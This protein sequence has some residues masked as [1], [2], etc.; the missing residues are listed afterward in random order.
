MRPARR[1]LSARYCCVLLVAC[2]SGGCGVQAMAEPSLVLFDGRVFTA[3]PARPEAQ[4]IAI[5]GE[6]IVAVGDDATILALAGST[7]RRI[8][9]GGRRVIPGLNDAH[10]H[11]SIEPADEVVADPGSP[12]PDWTGLSAALRRAE[13]GAARGAWLMATFGTTLFADRAV[14]RTALDRLWP[15]HPV[16][17]GSFDG[18]AAILN[19]A[20]LRRLGIGEDIADPAGG[21]FER[22][23]GGRLNG[24]VRE[25]ALGQVAGRLADLTSDADALAGLRHQIEAGARWGLTTIQDMPACG[26]VARQ[27]RLLAQMPS[28]IRIRLTRMNCTTPTGPDFDQNRDVGPHP[29]RLVSVNGTKWL[30]DGVTFE[31]TLTPRGTGLAQTAAA[32]GP[33]SPHDLAALPALFPPA[34]V[35][36]MLRDGLRRDEQL[37]FHVYGTPAAAELLDAMARTGGAAVWRGRRLRMEH[38]DGLTPALLRRA[39]AMGVVL[40][41]QGTHLDIGAI[42][43]GLLPGLL[44]RMRAARAEP[45]RS[46]LTAGMPLAL[47]SDGPLNPWLSIAGAV[48]DANRPDEAIS[49]TQA[50]LAYTAGSAFAEFTEGDRGRLIAGRLADLTVLDRD[51]LVVPVSALPDTHALLTV[52][53]GA[54]VWDA[55]ALPTS[56]R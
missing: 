6:R 33:G 28:P 3:D 29:S 47:G 1:R 42:D 41:Q 9:L 37:Q 24:V 4:A 8:D 39:R 30:L 10:A 34:V 2:L 32:R 25:Y 44:V 35:E 51:V 16:L 20:A 46:A 22:D 52:V 55:H 43:R 50:L 14:D 5:E 48:S 23:A 13:A 54:I 11:L 53:G 15:D 19:S 17:L 12:D 40:S 21:R 31:G 27:A 26:S 18:H 49:R 38:G 45:L 7:T 56:G 36:A